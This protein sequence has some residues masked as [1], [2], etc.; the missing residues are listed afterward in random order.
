MKH[1]YI[2]ETS[3]GMARV[4][5]IHT[6]CIIVFNRCIFINRLKRP[7]YYDSKGDAFRIEVPQG[8]LVMVHTKKPPLID[9]LKTLPPD[10]DKMI[11]LSEFKTDK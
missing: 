4:R 5:N 9:I 2:D 7:R 8:Q 11:D 3:G 6:S 1:I 10:D